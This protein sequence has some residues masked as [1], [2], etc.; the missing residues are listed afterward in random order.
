[1]RLLANHFTRTHGYIA[2][3]L[4]LVFSGFTLFLVCQPKNH[5]SVANIVVTTL[6]TVSGPMVGAVARDCQ[7]CCLKFSLFLLPWSGAFLAAGTLIQF[8]PLPFQRFA[9]ALR[10]TVWCLGLLGWFGG[11]VVSFGHAFS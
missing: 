6:A 9:R 2:L 1:M 8:V 4:L 5:E 11:G 3:G 7:S 10:L